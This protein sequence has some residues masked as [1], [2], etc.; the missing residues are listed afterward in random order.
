MAGGIKFTKIDISQAHLHVPVHPDDE[1]LLTLNTHK[2][3]YKSRRLI[4]GVASAPAI[5][6]D[7][8]RKF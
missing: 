6:R 3:L 8:L 7:K 5:F 1:H 2:G 4:Y